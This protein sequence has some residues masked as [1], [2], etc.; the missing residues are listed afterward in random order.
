MI[1]K[2][3][4]GEF[5]KK[6]AKAE[7]VGFLQESM[8]MIEGCVEIAD[9]IETAKENG[10][11]GNDDCDDE[12]DELLEILEGI[13]VNDYDN[14]RLFKNAAYSCIDAINFYL[15]E[16]V[17][18]IQNLNKNL[19]IVRNSGVYLSTEWA[20]VIQREASQ[21]VGGLC[22]VLW[23]EFDLGGYVKQ[24]E[25]EDRGVGA[26]IDDIYKTY[27]DSQSLNAFAEADNIRNL[28]L[29]YKFKL[30]IFD[31]VPELED[32]FEEVMGPHIGGINRDALT[33]DLVVKVIAGDITPE[34]VC[35]LTREKE[36]GTIDNLEY[37]D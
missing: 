5:I 18:R 15:D 34:D 7:L 17:Q 21:I 19:E 35:R 29:K 36:E 10:A 25:V 26:D 12:N 31:E 23:H 2:H 14:L 28:R 6:A 9:T 33:K 8:F 3:E 30:Q 11:I 27:V 1:V 16:M 13:N 24:I 32:V 22:Y 20:D 37:E 4:S